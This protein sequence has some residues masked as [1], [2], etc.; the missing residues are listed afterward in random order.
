MNTRTTPGTTEEDDFF[1][2]PATPRPPT[3]TQH[4]SPGQGP[5]LVSALDLVGILDEI[6]GVGTHIAQVV[7]A[8]IG[9]DMSVDRRSFCR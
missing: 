3:T 7:I 8:E 6:L 4:T 1:R 2:A 5:A 9:L